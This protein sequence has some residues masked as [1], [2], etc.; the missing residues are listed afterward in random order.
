MA[1]KYEPLVIAPTSHLL[2]TFAPNRP[3]LSVHNTAAKQH[4]RLNDAATESHKYD[5]DEKSKTAATTAA[6]R[7]PKL[8]HQQEK[9]Q[10][11]AQS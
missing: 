9:Q 1:I 6:Q 11:T 2:A 3:E 5:D 7:L 8:R 10:Q 4:D